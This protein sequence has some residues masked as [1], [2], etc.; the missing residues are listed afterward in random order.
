M[1][2]I[3]AV[4]PQNMA[5]FKQNVRFNLSDQKSTLIANS[6]VINFD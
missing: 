5:T 2:V 1:A 3:A 6:I 4:S